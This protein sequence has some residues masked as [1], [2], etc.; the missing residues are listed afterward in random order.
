VSPP[1]SLASRLALDWVGLPLVG[2]SGGLTWITWQVTWMFDPA[3]SYD[4]E[5]KRP[6]NAIGGLMGSISLFLYVVLAVLLMQFHF[7]LFLGALHFYT[8]FCVCLLHLHFVCAITMQFFWWN[9]VFVQLN[10]FYGSH[11]WLS[12]DIFNHWHRR[13]PNEAM[14]LLVCLKRFGRDVCRSIENL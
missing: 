1:V 14:K 9:T 5:D 4:M 11:K 6:L 7:F 13:H 12:Y 3:R 8:Y 2:C 10:F